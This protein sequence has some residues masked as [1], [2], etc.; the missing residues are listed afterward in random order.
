MRNTHG[1]GR[2]TRGSGP[3]VVRGESGLE[4]TPEAEQL[5]EETAAAARKREEDAEMVELLLRAMRMTG[6]VHAATR[7]RVS[8]TPI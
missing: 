3:C 7:A 4:G 8:F 1:S 2:N 5:A 6:E